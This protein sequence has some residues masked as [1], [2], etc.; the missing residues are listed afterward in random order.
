MLLLWSLLFGFWNFPAHSAQPKP[1][2][3]FILIDDF[4][5]SDLGCYGSKFYRTPNVDKLAA[6]GMRFTDAYAACPVC[7][8]TRAAIMTGKYPARLNLTDWL[9][10]RGDRPDQ[11]LKRPVINQQL[12][13]TEITV[14]EALKSAGY[15]TGH[16]GK[17][18]LGG[19]GFEPQKQGF[20]V[21]IA[22]DHTGSPLSYVAPYKRGERFMPGLEQ[23]PEG[24]YLTDRLT[25]EA[26][27]FIER[28]KD[29]PFFLYLPHYTVHIPLRAK[30]E[31]IAKYKHVDGRPGQQTNIIY[32]AMIESMDDSVGRLMRKLEELKL[33]ERTIIF[34]TGDNGG[35]ATT[36]GPNTPATINTPMREG[37]GYLYEGGTRVPLIVKW[38]GATKPGGISAVPV[39]SIDY[40]PTILEMCGVK[41]DAKVDGLSIASVLRGTGAPKRD[42]L[43]WHYPHYSNQGG[44]PG[45][46]IRDGDY[47][48]IEFYENGRWELFNVK[49]D[50]RESQNLTEKEPAIAKRL[51]TKLD[52]W[53]RSVNAQ[54]M[55][56][57]ENFVPN[58]QGKDGTITLPAR[59][60]EVHGLQLRYE[61]LPHKNTLGFWT[62][63]EDWANWEFEVTK[64]GAFT[65]EILQG[66]GTG[67][68][69]SEV[70]FTIGAQTLTTTVEDTGHFQNFK[71]RD[72]GSVR[73]DKP[74]RYTL[75]VKP[76]SKA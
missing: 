47:K 33:S 30:E 76:K 23:A 21:N 59:T 66:C 67:Q 57:N 40:F 72:I 46:V 63:V 74:G 61:P 17:W 26:E 3:I 1:N 14:A 37:K 64:P 8:P 42:G 16:I 18:H 41:S 4:G 73:L 50:P 6:E 15:V 49:T 20:D 28:N 29:K 13:L 38:P 68:G 75:T 48:L 27:K 53:R 71:P 25:A 36:E 62:R 43:Y 44:K 65:V 7:S 9:P 58:P 2:V 51:G 39:S 35:L 24:E 69:G 45:A 56:P 55:M 52:A 32:A 12:P 70:E 5:W 31:I 34:F 19:E 11:I 10:G 22:G 60:A 54:M